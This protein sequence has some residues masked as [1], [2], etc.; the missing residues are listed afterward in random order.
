M[1]L[2]RIWL[3]PRREATRRALS[4]RQVIHA[5][6]LAGY[7]PNAGEQRPLWRLDSD[8]AHGLGLFIVSAEVPSL[9]HIAEQFGWPSSEL[10]QAHT[11]RYDEFLHQLD[12]GQEFAFRLTANPTKSLSGRGGA[13]R[14]GR[15]IPLTTRAQQIEWLATRGERH[16]FF[17]AQSGAAESVGDPSL[18]DMR[19]N[20]AKAAVFNKGHGAEQTKVTLQLATFEGRLSVVDPDRL[21]SAL[22]AGIGRAKGYGCGLMTLAP[23]E[24]TARS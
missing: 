8:G 21:R 23:L 20:N 16:G 17:V 15:V 2:S 4:D 5:A 24:S 22:S 13:N 19:L 18:L 14:R 9:E 12:A 11:K 6:V 1:Y 3:N 7:P 10:G